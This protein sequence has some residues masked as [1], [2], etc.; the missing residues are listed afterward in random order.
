MDIKNLKNNLSLIG[1]ALVIS[2]LV[3]D[4][5]IEKKRPQIIYHKNITHDLANVSTGLTDKIFTSLISVGSS[6]LF[7][8]AEKNKTGTL[9]KIQIPAALKIIPALLIIDCFMYWWHRMNHRLPFLWR[10]HKFHHQDLYLNSTSAI[11]FHPAEIIISGLLRIIVFIPL[12]IEKK[13]LAIYE[14]IFFPVITLHHSNIEISQGL[15]FFLRKFIVSP[16][17]HRIHHSDKLSEAH[18][19]FG[20]VLPYWDMVFGSYTSLPAENLQFGIPDDH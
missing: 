6:P 15:D 4:Y 7:E 19:N 5:I 18:T 2:F 14:K 9:Q 8:K 10:F 17:M 1:K 12:G 3:I 16:E 13:Q 11:R 20:S